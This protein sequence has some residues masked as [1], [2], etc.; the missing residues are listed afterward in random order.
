[1][2]SRI[3][4]PTWSRSTAA[5]EM[6]ARIAAEADITVSTSEHH[7]EIAAEVSRGLLRRHVRLLR[8]LG[9]PARDQGRGRQRLTVDAVPR[10]FC[11]ASPGFFAP[12]KL[13][14]TGPPHSCASRA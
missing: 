10:T 6:H 11:P 7:V 3:A 14:T 2:V 9:R 5:H 13:P 12:V 4:V 1:M 8:K